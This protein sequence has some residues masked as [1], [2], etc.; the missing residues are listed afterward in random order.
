[1]REWNSIQCPRKPWEKKKKR[2]RTVAEGGAG[3]IEAVNGGSIEAVDGRSIF[4][5]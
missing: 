1:V 3:S 5:A 2:S 4:T